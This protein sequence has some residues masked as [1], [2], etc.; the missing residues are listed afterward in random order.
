MESGVT[1]I[2]WL[3]AGLVVVVLAS[4]IACM[5]M[6]FFFGRRIQTSAYLRDS[7]VSATKEEELR[8][9]LRALD[10]KR[11]AGPLDAA[12]PPPKGMDYRARAI[13]PDSGYAGHNPV[14][15]SHYGPSNETDE[16][17]AERL[18]IEEE[19]KKAE[20]Q[21]TKWADEEHLR[22]A[23]LRDK[24]AAD[25]QSRAE[26]KIPTSIDI[27][28]LGGGWSFLLEFSTVIVIIFVLLALGVI[29]AVTGKDV[30]TI[31]ASVAGYVLG[32]ASASLQKGQETPGGAR[33]T[34]V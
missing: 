19:E 15:G 30:T 16:E 2:S 29:G 18:K 11:R 23:A 27:S 31:L 34:K 4:C 32:K 21:F 28:L 1:S 12:H 20:E 13:W 22:Y 8:N 24:A 6:V 26:Q 14:A 5:W 7:I 25:A 3:Q 9:L 10:E 17:R 33:G